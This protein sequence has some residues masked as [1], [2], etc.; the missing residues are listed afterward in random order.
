MTATEQAERLQALQQVFDAMARL[1]AMLP[2]TNWELLLSVP[3]P[4][5]LDALHGATRYD[6]VFRRE[7][8]AY[9]SDPMAWL[10]KQS[11]C[12]VDELETFLAEGPYV[13]C[14]GTR[15]DGE[16][17]RTI[18]RIVRY[19]SD[20]ARYPPTY[21]HLHGACETEVDEGSIEA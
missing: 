3:I 21:C 10:A 16:P 6:C 13:R 18:V 14:S 2:G 4:E 17:C 20:F 19:P 7:V 9:V 1:K 11:R 8:V 5:P 15:K 12:T